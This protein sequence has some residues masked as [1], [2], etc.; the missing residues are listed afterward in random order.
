MRTVIAFA[1]ACYPYC[2]FDATTSAKRAAILAHYLPESGWRPIVIAYPWGKKVASW[3]E[4]Y[5]QS[6]TQ[7]SAIIPVD[8]GFHWAVRGQRWLRALGKKRP[9]LKGVA[10]LATW[11][12]WLPNWGIFD[13]ERAG[14]HRTA[15]K[16]GREIS[17]LEKVDA[18][19]ATWGKGYGCL[20]AA[21]RLS[22]ELDVPWVADIRDDWTLRKAEP[23]FLRR[24]KTSN[25]VR[26]AGRADLVT[27]VSG[28]LVELVRRRINPNAHL[29]YNGY[30]PN[31]G[32]RV[33]EESDGMFILVYT[34][35][36]DEGRALSLEIVCRAMKLLAREEPDF[37]RK[38]RFVYHGKSA[39]LVQPIITKCGLESQAV[40]SG[41]IPHSEARAVQRGG[42]VLVML[43][44]PKSMEPATMTAKIF[45]YLAARRP[46]LSVVGNPHTINL[47]LEETGAGVWADDLE[48]TVDVLRKWFRE[49]KQDG[50]L[51]YHGDADAIEEYSPR[52]QMSRLA[53][54]L[55]ELVGTSQ[56]TE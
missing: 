23:M 21:D 43:M 8:E 28:P 14:W 13:D 6:A 44:A 48:A 55:D 15:L 41:V 3:R 34:G 42:T 20:W 54:L 47:L 40:V 36:I 29:I 19:W 30:L 1:Q 46:I 18:I 4:L 37:A 32:P 35:S 45:D 51:T 53:A 7:S 11:L 56:L 39:A 25:L 38:A 52:R 27:S 22:S 10:L 17:R 2:P 33:E 49:W 31:M 12:L 5:A 16:V 50:R 24:L 26:L 9:R